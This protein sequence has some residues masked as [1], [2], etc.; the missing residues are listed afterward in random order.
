V[1]VPVPESADLAFHF[2]VESTVAC[3]WP[4]PAA[5]EAV[6][7]MRLGGVDPG[8]AA[9]MFAHAMELTM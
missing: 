6:C 7:L 1:L 4:R 3:G 8:M 5:F 2:A 9:A